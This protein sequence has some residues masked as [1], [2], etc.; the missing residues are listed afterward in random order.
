MY[1]KKQLFLSV[2]LG[3]ILTLYDFVIYGYFAQV[4]GSYFFP[5]KTEFVSILLAFCV[6]A[7]GAVVR[8]FSGFL[9]GFIGDTYGRKVALTF[10]IGMMGLATA[11]IAFIPSYLTIGVFS[12]ILLVTCRILQSLSISGEEVGSAIYLSE[13]FERKDSSVACSLIFSGIYSGLLLGSIVSFICL[14]FIPYHQIVT[15]GWRLPFLLS[16]PIAILCLLMR[17]RQPETPAFKQQLKQT[18][19]HSGSIA[20]S[21]QSFFSQMISASLLF[22]LMSVQVYLLAVYLPSYL[23]VTLKI[24]LYT[25]MLL[26]SI[27]FAVA[28]VCAPLFGYFSKIKGNKNIL[29]MSIWG[30]LLLC[31]PIFALLNT[32]AYGAIILAIIMVSLLLAMNAGSIMPIVLYQFPLSKRYIGSCVSFNLAMS[33]FGSISPI[34][35]LYSTKIFNSNVAPFLVLG[36]SALITIIGFLLI[37]TTRESLLCLSEQ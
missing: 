35:F 33:V 4:I 21:E 29:N 11:S 7:S 10:S 31:Y 18:Q 34:L 16:I 14:Y 5:V 12:P 37:S 8:P 1:S 3:N 20:S 36:F 23:S 26:C 6:F 9:F 28:L 15:W 30:S 2:F 22:S 27:G 32:A 13:M 19:Q 25:T 17:I 24:S